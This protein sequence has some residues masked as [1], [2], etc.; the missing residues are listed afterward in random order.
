MSHR[1]GASN[2]SINNNTALLLN[3]PHRYNSNNISPREV[4]NQLTP[5]ISTANAG[6]TSH[7]AISN[8]HLGIF[9]LNVS[10]NYGKVGWGI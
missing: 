6:Y 7:R 1:G 9:N 5:Q 4:T 10:S 8:C 2:N 3:M